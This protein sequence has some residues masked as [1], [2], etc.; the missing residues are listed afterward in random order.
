[1]RFFAE[2]KTRLIFRSLLNEHSIELARFAGAASDSV[3]IDAE[4]KFTPK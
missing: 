4:L 3:Q 1:M 2:R